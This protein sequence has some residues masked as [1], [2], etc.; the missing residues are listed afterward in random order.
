MYIRMY[1]CICKAKPQYMREQQK[2]VKKISWPPLALTVMGLCYK[3][4]GAAVGV[5]V[6]VGVAM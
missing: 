6:G 4:H 3:A 2:L 5:V 1:I